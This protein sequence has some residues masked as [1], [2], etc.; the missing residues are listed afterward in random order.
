MWQYEIKQFRSKKDESAGAKAIIVLMYLSIKR[1]N[2]AYQM[3]RELDKQLTE[4]NGWSK[5]QLENFLSLKKDNKLHELLEAM[6]EKGFLLSKYERVK[7][8]TR[9]SYYIDERIIYQ[10]GFLTRILNTNKDS[11]E[12]K[13]VQL[14][15]EFLDELGHKDSEE[16]QTYFREWSELKKFDF[17]IFLGFLKYE[18][19]KM[20]KQEIVRIISNNIKNIKK[21]EKEAIIASITSDITNK[22]LQDY[23][24][25]GIYKDP[26]DLSAVEGLIKKFNE[27][28]TK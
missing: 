9:Q 27:S 24:D 15:K 4:E 1:G 7:G 20:G 28:N 6:E 11:N 16:I 5:D 18:A 10:P 25:R 23:E 21:L 17:F 8:R 22:N 26:G 14:V 19:S 3:A 13:K 2:W 12:K